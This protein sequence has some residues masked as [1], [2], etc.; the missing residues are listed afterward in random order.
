MKLFRMNYL[1]YKTFAG[2]I[3]ETVDVKHTL[4]DTLLH[5][6]LLLTTRSSCIINN[7]ANQ[8]VSIILVK[9]KFK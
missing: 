2:E 1:H 9:N 8:P 7:Y 6:L 5:K 3:I 4:H